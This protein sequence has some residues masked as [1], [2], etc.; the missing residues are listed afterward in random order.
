MISIFSYYQVQYRNFSRVFFMRIQALGHWARYFISVFSI[1]FLFFTLGFPQTLAAEDFGTVIHSS[2]EVFLQRT[3]A[4]EW[5]RVTGGDRLRQGMA[6]RTGLDSVLLIVNPD[7]LLTII[8]ESVT[9]RYNPYV[10]SGTDFESGQ[11]DTLLKSYFERID[12]G[13]TAQMRGITDYQDKWLNLLSKKRFSPGDLETSFEL[14]NYYNGV[15]KKNRVSALLWKLKQVYPENPCFFQLTRKSLE[16]YQAGA[17]WQ[18]IQYVQGRK[19]FI[20][21][22]NRILDKGLIQIEYVKD[23][24]SYHYLFMTSQPISGKM[25][26]R[27]IFPRSVSARKKINNLPYLEARSAPR[28]KAQVTVAAALTENEK[29]GTEHFWGWSCN[30]PVMEKKIVDRAVKAVENHL[31]K[32]KMLTH[33]VIHTSAP[34]LCQSSF[35][36]TLQIIEQQSLASSGKKR[37]IPFYW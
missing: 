33:T 8:P 29:K 11:F 3:D 26:T 20:R 4:S 30:G 35:A 25:R 19:S 31:K 34:M 24:E 36:M 32:H 22:G 14:I 15:G 2:G 16:G 10:L 5:I 1:S 6:I 28:E 17:K 23:E 21:N 7:G 9:F 18:V 37:F 12:F 13:Y 27:M